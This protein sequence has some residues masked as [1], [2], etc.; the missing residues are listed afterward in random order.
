[1]RPLSLELKNFGSYKS[2]TI[3]FDDF[4]IAVFRRGKCKHRTARKQCKTQREQ[5]D[6]F[7]SGF[8]TYTLL[9]DLLKGNASLCLRP[10]V[11]L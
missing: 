4:D 3:S 10:S 11:L 6:S 7:C 1:M 5:Q 2:E 8:H 9:F